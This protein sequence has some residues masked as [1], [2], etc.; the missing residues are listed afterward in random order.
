[1]AMMEILG[2]DR[3]SAFKCLSPNCGCGLSSVVMKVSGQELLVESTCTAGHVSIYRYKEAGKEIQTPKKPE[4]T[5]RTKVSGVTF[6]NPDGVSRQE[7]LKRLRAGDELEIV[8]GS[9]DNQTVYQVRH[10]IGVIGTLKGDIVRSIDT[11]G[12]KKELFAKVVQ[13]TGGKGEKATYGCNI[14]LYTKPAKNLVYMDPDGKNIYHRNPHC[15]GMQDTNAVTLEY[16]K[17][18]LRAR[19]CKKCAGDDVKDNNEKKVRR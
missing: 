11:D 17:E 9:L 1:M 12:G 10:A 18:E 8:K 16:A 15:S 5:I 13:I 14:E 7:L 19:P 4:P 3:E 6:K 2:G